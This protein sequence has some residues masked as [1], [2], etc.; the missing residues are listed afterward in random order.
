MSGK[1]PPKLLRVGADAVKSALLKAPEER[2]ERDLRH[3][4]AAMSHVSCL[5]SLDEEGRAS[6]ARNASMEE[7]GEGEA[8]F[9]QGQSGER[10]FLVLEGNVRLVTA[11]PT[12]D[13]GEGEGKGEGET[14][15]GRHDPSAPSPSLLQRQLTRREEREREAVVEEG[16]GAFLGEEAIRQAAGCIRP[17]SALAAGSCAV[18]VIQQ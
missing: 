2:T 14:E 17:C 4:G 3:I 15:G 16:V 11:A 5:A 10:A 13:G 9:T 1:A 8:I 18:I 12:V 7:F 6:L